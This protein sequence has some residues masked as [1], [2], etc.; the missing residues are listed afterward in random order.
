MKMRNWTPA[1]IVL[2]LPIAATEESLSSISRSTTATCNVGVV[3][4]T[5]SGDQHSTNG[6]GSEGGQNHGGCYIC[7][8]RATGEPVYALL[9]HQCGFEQGGDEGDAEEEGAYH[10]LLTAAEQ[11][12]ISQVLELAHKVPDRVSLNVERS[13]LQIRSCDGGFIGNVRLS[14]QHVASL[15]QALQANADGPMP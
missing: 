6:A 10:A 15:H 12:D 9:C 14:G 8:D 13:S 7:R 4:L 1:L 11:S 5:C 3:I 2:G